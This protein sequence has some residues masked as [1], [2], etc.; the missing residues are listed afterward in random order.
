MDHHGAQ[1]STKM[2]SLRRRAWVRALAKSFWMKGSAVALA[3]AGAAAEASNSHS[4]SVF[5]ADGYGAPNCIGLYARQCW[6]VCSRPVIGC[7]RRDGQQR[8]TACRVG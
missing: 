4:K 7:L 1:H 2:G 3:T 6:M 5:M 8:I